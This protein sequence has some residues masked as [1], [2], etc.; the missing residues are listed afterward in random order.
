M[1]AFLFAKENH[2][3]YRKWLGNPY[4]WCVRYNKNP[5]LSKIPKTQL[6]IPYFRIPYIEGV[7]VE[8]R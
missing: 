3:Q 1:G 5:L 2:L 6:I 4:E 8:Y 7:G